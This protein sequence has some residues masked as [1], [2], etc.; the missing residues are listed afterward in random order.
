MP[1]NTTS[2]I[3]Q[4][5]AASYPAVLAAVRKPENQ[6]AESAFMRELQRQ[7]AIDSINFGPTLEAALDWR[8]NPGAG[9][10]TNE[11]DPVSLA[12]TDVIAAASYS[13]AELTIPIVWTKKD[14]VQNPS[15]NQKVALVKSLLTNAIDSHDDLVEEAIFG[16]STAGF[17]G[18]QT[19]VPDNGQ[20]SVGGIDAALDLMWRNPVSTYTNA[21]DIVASFTTCWNNVS[22]G[23][24]SALSP[25][26]M[27]SG[28]TP[29]AQYESTQQGLQR[30]V[31]KD[32]ADAGF[33]IL[34]FKTA[35]YVFSQYGSTRIYMLNPKSF[36]I[37]VAK[38][39]FREKGD[40]QEMEGSNGYVTKVY[41]ALQ[42]LTN[43]KS[44]CGLVRL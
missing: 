31:D 30:Y 29:H 35:R 40:T 18:L 10:Q 1:L 24:G 14:E 23:S 9:F 41:S 26:F 15:E 44:R 25:K 36:G 43:N 21:T 7:G 38:G 20:T 12:K 27:V 19:I 17:L 2:A 5:A 37:K 3:A 8:R 22:K 32:E 33:K 39:F 4:M 16:V 34:A 13:I 6:W 11:L 42:A 28:S